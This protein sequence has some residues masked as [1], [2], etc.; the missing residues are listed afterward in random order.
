MWL[1]LTHMMVAGS[2]QTAQRQREKSME[3]RVTPSHVIYPAITKVS[4]CHVLWFSLSHRFTQLSG[5]NYFIMLFFSLTKSNCMCFMVQHDA[6]RNVYLKNEQIRLIN[7]SI[8]SYI[9]LF[10]VRMFKIHLVVILNH[11]VPYY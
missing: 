8:T 11:T 1:V 4:F 7:I 5:E 9:Y 10:V 6:F 2:Q 3:T